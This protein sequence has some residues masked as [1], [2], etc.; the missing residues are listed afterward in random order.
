VAAWED[1]GTTDPDGPAHTS[2]AAR[3][4]DAA[5]T[6]G[7]LF[8]WARGRPGGGVPRVGRGT[9]RPAARSAPREI[10]GVRRWIA[11]LL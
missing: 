10:A 11:R 4:S 6:V 7:V 9:G 5:A 2:G 8:P 1:P 3:F